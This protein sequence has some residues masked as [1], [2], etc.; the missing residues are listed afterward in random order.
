MT[1]P[2]GCCCSIDGFTE[3]SPRLAFGVSVAVVTF[4]LA[5]LLAVVDVISISEAPESVLIAPS[6]SDD[7]ADAMSLMFICCWVRRDPLILLGFFGDD[8]Y[9]VNFVSLLFGI[10]AVGEALA[11][12]K[13]RRGRDI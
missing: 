8:I 13:E 12:P 5:L 9:L 1:D 11:L 3:A 10:F 7:D 4:A 2:D 6:S